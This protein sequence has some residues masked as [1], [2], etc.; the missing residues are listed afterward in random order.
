MYPHLLVSTCDRP[1]SSLTENKFS[2]SR[3][4]YAL[5]IQTCR[6][7]SSLVTMMCQYLR[8]KRVRM[9][10]CPRM[11]L[12]TSKATE[13]PGKTCRTRMGTLRTRIQVF[14]ITPILCIFLYTNAMVHRHPRPSAG[15]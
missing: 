15:H 12:N 6:W 8:T 7:Q 2:T 9:S 11:A 4:V 1:I 5:M 14:A 3:V 13:Y 10:F